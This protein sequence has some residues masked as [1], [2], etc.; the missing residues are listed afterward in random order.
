MEVCLTAI[1]VEDNPM[2]MGDSHEFV[3]MFVIFL[4][5][6]SMNNYIICNTYHSITVGED[7]VHHPLKDIL[8]TG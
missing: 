4:V 2:L 8:H 6:L 5:I 3:E 7:L 1:L